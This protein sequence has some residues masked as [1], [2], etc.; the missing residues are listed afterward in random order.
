MSEVL[1][2]DIMLKVRGSFSWINDFADIPDHLS[3]G[4]FLKGNVVQ[5]LLDFISFQ[6]MSDKTGRKPALG[7]ER[8]TAGH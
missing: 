5:E 8:T 4:L 6:R 3:G 2:Y 7:Q 1:P